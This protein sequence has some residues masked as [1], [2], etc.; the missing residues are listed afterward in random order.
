MH[1]SI[2]FRHKAISTYGWE[3]IAKSLIVQKQQHFLKTVICAGDFFLCGEKFADRNWS[4]EAGH[5]ALLQSFYVGLDCV[6]LVVLL[7]VVS[8]DWCHKLWVLS[9]T[10]KQGHRLKRDRNDVDH[11][12]GE[13]K[14]EI[15]QSTITQGT[16]QLLSIPLVQHFNKWLTNMI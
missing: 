15:N 7:Q 3:E 2:Q 10:G 6:S 1:S 9:V 11:W 8:S 12:S 5:L 4:Q 16:T 13:R 14:G